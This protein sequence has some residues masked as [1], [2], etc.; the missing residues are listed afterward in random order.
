[1]FFSDN[2]LRVELD[3]QLAQTGPVLLLLVVVIAAEGLTLI[4]GYAFGP[5]DGFLPLGRWGSAEVTG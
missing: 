4:S 1:M 3:F 2:E 5:T